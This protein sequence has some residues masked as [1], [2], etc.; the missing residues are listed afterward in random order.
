MILSQLSARPSGWRV[1][2]PGDMSE[3]E[4]EIGVPAAWPAELAWGLGKDEFAA[5][6]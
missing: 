4:I 3:D 1:S 2:S 5:C 6:Y